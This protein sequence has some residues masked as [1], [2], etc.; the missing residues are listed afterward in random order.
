MQ[1]IPFAYF[2]P[3]LYLGF[4]NRIKF[5]FCTSYR[6]GYETALSFPFC[7]IFTWGFIFPL[8][9]I[10]APSLGEVKLSHFWHHLYVRF[11]FFNVKI[12]AKTPSP[13]FGVVFSFFYL[14]SF[15]SPFCF[16]FFNHFKTRLIWVENFSYPL[17]FFPFSQKTAPNF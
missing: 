11:F 5:H 17:L 1:K 7:T 15:I 6:W 2:L 4:L 8:F 12:S 16:L 10:F 3:H 14:F 13:L 9:I